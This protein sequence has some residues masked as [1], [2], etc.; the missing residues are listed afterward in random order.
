[1]FIE[2]VCYLCSVSW[3]RCRCITERP[4]TGLHPVPGEESSVMVSNPNPSELGGRLGP[5][6]SGKLRLK[7][8]KENAGYTESGQAQFTRKNLDEKPRVRGRG[9]R[10]HSTGRG[11]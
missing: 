6:A 3:E 2:L 4:G 7:P 1:M 8:W 9:P 10:R 5:L 11:R